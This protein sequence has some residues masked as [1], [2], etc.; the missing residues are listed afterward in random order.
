M[1]KTKFGLLS[2]IIYPADLRKL[3]VEQLPEICKE[4]REDIID[5]VSVN[6]G[7]FASSL[8]VVEITVALHY[9]YNTPEDRIVW[10]V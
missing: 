3:N 2:N 9:V 5:E 6:P 8:G 7:H 4:L 1:D 10:D